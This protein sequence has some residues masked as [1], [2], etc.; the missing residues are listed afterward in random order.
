MDTIQIASGFTPISQPI[1]RLFELAYNLWWTWHPQGAELFRAIDASLWEEVYHNPVR[2]LREV[3]QA[4]LDEVARGP[5]FLRQYHSVMADFDTYMAGVNTWFSRTYPDGKN[6]PIAYFSAEFGLHEVL[7][8]Y[9]GGLGVLSGDHCKEASDLGLPFVGIGFLY[10]QGY[11]RQQITA[12][13]TQEAIYE[14]LNF[15]EVPA[16]PAFDRDGREIVVE[17][18]LPGRMVYAKVWKIQVGRVPLYLMDTDIHPNAPPDRHLSARLYGGDREMRLSQEM[19]L[20]IGGVRALRALGIQPSAWHV[21]EGHAAFLLLER[22]RGLVQTGTSFDQAAERVRA[23]SAF[24]THT[25]VPAGHD[26]FTFDLM[27]RFF[28]GYWEKLGL[29]RDEFLNVARQDQPWG[30][31]FSMTVLGLKLA[32]HYNGV[33]RLHG[34][35]SRKMWHFL[36]PDRPVDQV[37]IQAITNGIHTES[38]LAPELKALFDEYLPQGWIDAID[39]PVTWEGVL[40]IPDQDLW[41]VRQQLRRRLVDFV[42]HRT[43]VHLERLGAEPWQLHAIHSLLDPEILTIGFARRFATY[44]RATLL[45]TEVERLKHILNQPERPVQ[46]VFAGKAHPADEPGKDFIRQVYNR[47]KEPGLAGRIVFLE[48]YDINMARYLVQGADVWLNT[49]R[50]PHEASGTSGQKAALNGVPN[51]SV[52][53]GWWVEGY[54]GKN[55]WVVGHAK[56]YSDP[57]AQDWEDSQSL[58][59]LLEKTIVPLFYDCDDQGVPAGWLKFVKGSIQSIA[60]AFSTTRMV[61]DYARKMY[62]SAM[63]AGK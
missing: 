60:P 53:D 45:F 9:S 1:G 3:R 25:P 4:T 52:M 32:G 51:L 59:Q 18:Q 15:A 40:S 58:Y 19:V 23:T 37:P 26:V 30:P 42:R 43:R 20:G 47:A 35:V 6:G 33:S 39:D 24:T 31:T 44:K 28:A 62:L 8:I 22:V 17:V 29:S 56:E 2:F 41:D 27:D 46:I 49:P 7:P 57:G 54:N 34:E 21:N 10:P 50:R 36:W 38:W 5:E 63:E 11:F 48:D 55:G 13:G 16:L 14:K 61:K 12:E